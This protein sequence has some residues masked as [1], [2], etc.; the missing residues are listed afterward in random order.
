MRSENMSFDIFFCW[1]K[2]ERVNFDDVKRWAE[3]IECFKQ[4]GTQLWYANP[5]TGVYFSIDFAGTPESPDDAPL[6]PDGYFDSGLSFNLNYNRPQYFAL[7]AMPIVAHLATRFGLSLIDP[8]KDWDAPPVTRVAD[9]EVLVS[10]WINH[11]ERATHALMQDPD[12]SNPLH[13]TAQ[14][15]VYLWR[16]TKAKPDLER[17]C[18]EDMFVPRLVPIQRKG[19]R[20]VGAAFTYTQ[21][22]PMIVPESEWVILVRKNRRFSLKKKAQEITV[23]N[24][25]TFAE[26]LAGCIRPYD[27]PELNVQMITPESAQKA[28]EITSKIDRTLPRSEFDVIEKDAFVDIQLPASS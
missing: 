13:M 18:G 20:Q 11:N 17:A 7:E 5:D 23:I 6:I 8:Q 14:D 10:S 21:G 26:L 16:Y 24:A 15:S 9:A 12:F 4:N 19:S 1:P 28:A 2:N 25:R 22:I 3:A 27:W